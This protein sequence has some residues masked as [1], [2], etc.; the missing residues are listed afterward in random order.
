MHITSRVYSSEENIFIEP[1]LELNIGA[2]KTAPKTDYFS[3]FFHFGSKYSRP[4]AKPRFNFITKLLFR[5]ECRGETPF[6]SSY[7]HRFIFFNGNTKLKAAAAAAAVT[8]SRQ[9]SHEY[10]LSDE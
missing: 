6:A 7:F 4:T 8:I 2:E 5:R 3:V 1:G 10:Q 9:A